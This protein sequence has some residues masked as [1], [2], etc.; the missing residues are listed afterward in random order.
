MDARYELGGYREL[1]PPPGLARILECTWLYCRP[2]HGDVAHRVLPDMNVNIRFICRRAK[3]GAVIDGELS[4]AG[5]TDVV[6][7][8]RPDP[9]LR[10]EAIG[11][12]SEWCR[13]VLG[14]DARDHHD[15]MVPLSDVAPRIAAR[16]RDRMM[17]TGGPAEA[18]EALASGL[19]ETHET[20]DAV[21]AHHA[22]QVLRRRPAR[23]AAVARALHVSERHLRRVI[24]DNA[25]TSPKHIQRIRRLNVAV[26]AADRSA[27]PDWSSL[28]LDAG[29][30]DQPHLIAEVRALTGLTPNALHAER[31]AQTI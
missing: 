10:I 12:H 19:Q 8:F 27:K 28:A 4:F 30:Y 11:V 13:A 29:F 7:V 1:A 6:R 26:A 23:I 22:L 21:L 9:D 18:I 3:S 2:D 5:P 20:R 15:V 24:V 25:G 17:R 16:L 14:L 31:Q